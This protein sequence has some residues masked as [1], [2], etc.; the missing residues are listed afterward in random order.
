VRKRLDG[1]LVGL[2]GALVLGLVDLVTSGG[3]STRRTVGEGVVAGNVA[4]GLLLVGLLGCLGGLALDG[5][6]DVVGG[7]LDGVDGLADDALVG[8]VGVGSRH[9]GVRLVGW[10]VWVESGSVG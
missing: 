7:V 8:C 10:L 3:E 2:G 1:A 5:L 9:C 4:L 6:R